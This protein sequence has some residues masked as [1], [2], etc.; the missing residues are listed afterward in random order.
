MTAVGVETAHHPAKERHV[1]ACVCGARALRLSFS[2]F[3]HMRRWLVCR[4]CG[5]RC[6]VPN[7]KETAR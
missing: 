4:S 3:P 2:R 1:P 7:R 6:P 5:R